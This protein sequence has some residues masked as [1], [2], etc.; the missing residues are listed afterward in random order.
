MSGRSTVARWM[1]R[2]VPRLTGG[3]EHPLTGSLFLRGASKVMIVIHWSLFGSSTFQLDR[4]RMDPLAKR[5]LFVWKFSKSW[6]SCPLWKIGGLHYIFDYGSCEGLV[7]V[8]LLSLVIVVTGMGFFFFLT[9]STHVTNVL[10]LYLTGT[11]KPITL[12]C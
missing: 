11:H 8:G 7:A 6:F 1:G 3:E 2:G 10:S 9:L 4:R 12:P 5:S